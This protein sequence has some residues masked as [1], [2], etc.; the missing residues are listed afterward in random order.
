M[1]FQL[2]CNKMLFKY[3]WSQSQHCNNRYSRTRRRSL[4]IKQ[5]EES[6]CAHDSAID[7]SL[8]PL[9]REWRVYVDALCAPSWLFP[10]R[11]LIL[12]SSHALMIM[13][14]CIKVVYVTSSNLEDFEGKKEINKAQ[15]EEIGCL[16]IV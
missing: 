14:L 3:I 2:D 12:N 5:G 6:S 13:T 7:P 10:P 15:N 9:R 11:S 4:L 8:T 16:S 1:L